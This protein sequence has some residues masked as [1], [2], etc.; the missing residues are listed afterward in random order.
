MKFG[1]LEDISSIDF[2][3]PSDHSITAKVL[4]NK[5]ARQVK[6]YAGCP[7]WADKGF[8][9]RIYPKG[10]KAKDYLK[11]Y[12]TQFNAIELNATGYQIPTKEEVRAWTSVVPKGFVF[13]P[14]ISQPISHV[15]PLAKDR[16]ALNR[17]CDAMHQFGKHLG[18]VFLQLHPSFAPARFDDLLNF[19]DI[20]DTSL[21]LHIELRHPDWFSDPKLQTKLFAEMRKRKIGTVIT[22]TAGRRDAV[23]QG[24]TTRSAFI[25]FDGNDLH[26]TDLTRIDEW[27]AHIKNWI[28][29]GLR[30]VYFFPHTT[31]KYLNPELS[32]YFLMRIN[33]LHGSSYTLATITEK[34]NSAD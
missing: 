32:N 17:F 31:A 15:R 29:H 18:T 10:T 20:W 13:C 28:D 24:L 3:L 33:Q 25:R 23:H 34:R 16:E 12:A 1:H 19:F 26:R 8:M 9:G 21:P 22:D 6:V 4:S 7:V 11:V 5:P 2:S 27:A 14:K 30:E